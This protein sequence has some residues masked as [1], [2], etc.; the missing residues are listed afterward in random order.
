MYVCMYVF[1]IGVNA[2]GA[3]ML[4]V[5]TSQ[6]FPKDLAPLFITGAPSVHTMHVLVLLYMFPRTTIN[7]SSFS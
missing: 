7:V 1:Y 2:F 5:V 4:G 3:L 6:K